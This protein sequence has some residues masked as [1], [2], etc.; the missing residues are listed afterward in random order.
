[1]LRKQG[2]DGAYIIDT[3]AKTI[4]DLKGFNYDGYQFDANLQK[5]I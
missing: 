4:E 5:E 2:D 1:L 3:E